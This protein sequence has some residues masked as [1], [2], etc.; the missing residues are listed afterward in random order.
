M[1]LPALPALAQT[2]GPQD[3]VAVVTAF[4][5]AAKAKNFDLAMTYFADNAT[6]TDNTGATFGGGTTTY[7]NLNDIRKQF[8]ETTPTDLQILSAQTSGNTATVVA[9]STEVI[10]AGP[11]GVALPGVTHL[12]FMLTATVENGKIQTVILD[13]TEQSKTDVLTG[14]AQT[15]GQAN[16][17]MPRT[18]S[19]DQ[20]ALPLGLA[21]L[22]VLL[23][24]VG[25]V[26][27]RAR[28]WE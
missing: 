19:G 28:A 11:G 9:R 8:V 27:V 10:T 20:P 24:A 18:G 1:I 17:G 14:L 3:P 25:A 7:T 21:L 26:M 23:V 2:G 16:P 4:T 5:N 22:G 12:D 6:M 15:S 13:L